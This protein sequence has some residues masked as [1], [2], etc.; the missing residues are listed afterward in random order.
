MSAYLIARVNITDTEQYAEYR[1]LTP[2]IIE[3]FG[4]RFIAR[5]GEIVTLEGAAETGRVVIIEFPSVEQVQAFYDSPEYQRAK[6]IR[7]GAS[8]AQFI[9]VDGV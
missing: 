6:S 7:D 5:G 9:I 1:K 3:Q 4:G 2:A 8:T